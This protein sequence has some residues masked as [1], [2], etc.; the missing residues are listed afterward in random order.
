MY[1]Y[2]CHHVCLFACLATCLSVCLSAFLPGF[3]PVCVCLYSVCMY[4]CVS[5]YVKLKFKLKLV[6]L[7]STYYN[8]A[9]PFLKCF[10]IL[11]YN[12]PAQAL[13]TV[14]FLCEGSHLLPSQLPGDHTGHKAASR[15]SE[16][17][18]NAHYS[19]THHQC[20]YSFYLPTEG[21][22]A[23]STPARLSWEWVLNPG[24]VA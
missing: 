3:L 16:P 8:R 13:S 18:W 20:W 19:S 15:C 24:P 21:W 10:T 22:R 23:E 6:N 7:C 12:F 5:L 17:T 11:T 14:S 2:A 9:M 1:M 4:V